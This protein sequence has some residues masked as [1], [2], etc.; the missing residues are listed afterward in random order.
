MNETMLD[1]NTLQEE[2]QNKETSSENYNERIEGSPLWL[3][4]GM[5]DKWLLTFGQYKLKEADTKEELTVY[6]EFNAMNIV[7]DLI[8]II[9]EI[10]NQKTK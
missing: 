3:R 4:K 1:T 9:M 10:E 7:V 8:T 2:N 5:N 6:V